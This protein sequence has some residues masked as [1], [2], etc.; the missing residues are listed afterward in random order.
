MLTFEE[1]YYAIDMYE[2]LANKKLE[3]M[4]EI[5]NE[6]TSA[7]LEGIM[8]VRRTFEELEKIGE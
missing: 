1:I 7:F 6:Q 8:G 3:L 5:T 2:E 4:D